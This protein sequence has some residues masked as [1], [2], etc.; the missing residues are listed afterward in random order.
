M[1]NFNKYLDSIISEAAIDSSN[2][3]YKKF[4]WRWGRT[5]RQI[6]DSKVRD[7][8]ALKMTEELFN[9]FKSNLEKTIELTSPGGNDCKATILNLNEETGMIE[10]ETQGPLRSY[11]GSEDSSK[12]EKYNWNIGLLM[13]NELYDKFIDLVKPVLDQ[14]KKEKEAEREEKRR[15]AEEKKA[16]YASEEIQK[17]IKDFKIPW[18]DYCFSSGSPKFPE[19]IEETFKT[20]DDKT[21]T[22]IINYYDDYKFS[23]PNI[24]YYDGSDYFRERDRLDKANKKNEEFV[25]KLKEM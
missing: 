23:D 9:F 21:K 10:V 22:A 15:L 5:F 20:L 7:E 19:K 17:I 11:Y 24:E 8:I 2:P 3:V 6:P 16:T 12:K 1:N 14:I 18:A 4:I 13:T 25:L